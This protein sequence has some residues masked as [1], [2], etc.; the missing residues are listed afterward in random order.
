MRIC[1]TTLETIKDYLPPYEV[2]SV[3]EVGSQ[4]WGMSDLSSDHD[5]VVIY[6]ESTMDILK[7][8][9]IHPTLPSK[10]HIW[11]NDQE[12]DFSYLEIGHFCHQLKKGNI[13]MIWVLLSPIVIYQTKQVRI[14]YDTISAVHT[15]DI[16]PSGLGMTESQLRDVVKRADQRSPEKSLKTAYRTSNFILN[17]LQTGEWQFQGTQKDVTESEVRDIM[18]SIRTFDL[19]RD[20]P[21]MPIDAIEYWLY[22]LRIT[23]L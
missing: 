22:H 8:R 14:L 6:S 4:M 3:T 2:I 13:N 20:L 11:I 15:R 17:H 23:T 21:G 10:H 7:G 9:S 12:Y 1:M 5:L 16:I 19:N 18:D